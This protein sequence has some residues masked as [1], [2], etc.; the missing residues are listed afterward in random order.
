MF[1]CMFKYIKKLL[2]INNFYII[3]YLCISKCLNIKKIQEYLRE[4][5]IMMQ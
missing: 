4:I 1:D 2:N 3:Y 5:N